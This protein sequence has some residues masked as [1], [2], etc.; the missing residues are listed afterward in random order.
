MN[1]TTPVEN[2]A[3]E[4]PRTSTRSDEWRKRIAA[5]KT[6]RDQV[7]VDLNLASKDARA[8]WQG[9]DARIRIAQQRLLQGTRTAVLGPLVE[10]VRR[11]ARR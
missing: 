6:L 10:R 5:L 1:D 4:P 7:R 11:S 3:K 8:R 9:I 2:N